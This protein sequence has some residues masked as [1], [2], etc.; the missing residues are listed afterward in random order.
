MTPSQKT[1]VILGNFDGVHLG[2]RAILTSAKKSLSQGKADAVLA[3]LLD[4]TPAPKG[5]FLNT[6]EEKESL[7]LQNGATGIEYISFSQVKN[8][9]AKEFIEKKLLPLNIS[10]A[11][12][13]FNYRFG[14]NAGYDARDLELLGKEHGFET[15]CVPAVK[16]GDDIVSSTLIRKLLLEGKTNDACRLL[17]APYSFTSEVIKGE[18]RGEGLGFPTCNT[19]F[20]KG[21]L[22]PARGVY[23]TET[24][25]DGKRYP[26]ITDIGTRP[27]FNGD[28]GEVRAETHILRK[29]SGKFYNKE[30]SVSF[31]KY[32]REEIAFSSPDLLIK[33]VEKD[34]R[35][36]FDFFEID[37][38]K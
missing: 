14:K 2:H 24:L 16:S 8:Y 1:A 19:L 10:F 23:I 30:I 28:E 15:V 21:K 18:G 12:C 22:V 37:I 27:T 13:G 25:F 38:E 34:K 11:L 3:C 20:P 32:I 7:L 29:T 9:T 26:S 6:K 36:A 5:G 33:Q 31:L 35:K 17:G 4:G